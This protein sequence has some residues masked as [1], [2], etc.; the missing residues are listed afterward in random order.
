MNE[1]SI[2]KLETHKLF[3]ILTK[4]ISVFFGA[5]EFIKY[6]FLRWTRFDY[7]ELFCLCRRSPVTEVPVIDVRI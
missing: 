1:I 4:C 3:N 6:N 7:A 2:W 5:T